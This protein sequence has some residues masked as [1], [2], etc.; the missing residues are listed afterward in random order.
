AG[1]PETL[2]MQGTTGQSQSVTFPN[3]TVFG[4][5]SSKEA[6]SLAQIAVDS[7]NNN[8]KE[9]SAI[10]S[11]QAKDTASLEAG[12]AAE[13]QAAAHEAAVL[14]SLQSK[15]LQTSQKAVRMLEQL[16]AQQGTGQITLFFPTGSVRIA[17]G[18]L[19][20]DRLVQFLDYLSRQSRGRKVLF[21][22]I[23]SASAIGN[24]EINQRL[25]TERADAPK[26]IIN[27]YLVNVPHEFYR[28]A[29]IG[30][31]YS[32]KDASL[33]MDQRYQNVRIIAVYQTDQVPLLP[34]DSKSKG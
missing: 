17:Q 10:Q 6:G 4:G 27:Q 7:N 23:G 20:Y 19:Q 25:S 28:I 15:D 31:A 24:M 22:M 9:F 5:A 12:Q 2:S 8:M 18:T 34:E 1:Q 3:G 26:P 11:A 32:P 33:S 13:R 21:V 14:Q 16:S 30:D 29:G